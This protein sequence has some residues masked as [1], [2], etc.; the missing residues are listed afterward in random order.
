MIENLQ[1]YIELSFLAS[2]NDA[3]IQEGDETRASKKMN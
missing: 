3:L 2:D 1:K